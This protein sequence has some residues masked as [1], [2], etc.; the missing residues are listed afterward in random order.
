MED[1]THQIPNL[2]SRSFRPPDAIQPFFNSDRLDLI[3]PVISPARKNPGPQIAFVCGS[4]RERFASLILTDQLLEPVMSDQFGDRARSGFRMRGLLVGV[5][6]QRLGCFA[7]RCFGW[8]SLDSSDY[9][10]PAFT[11]SVRGGFPPAQDPNIGPTLPLFALNAS[12]LI[13]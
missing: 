6:A 13:P 2:R 5:N 10:L 3:Q 12:L 9:C 4:R 1:G 8:Q 7:C 11:R